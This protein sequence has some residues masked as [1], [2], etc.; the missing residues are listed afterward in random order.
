MLS[1]KNLKDVDSLK[2]LNLDIIMM[3][4]PPNNNWSFN[5]LFNLKNNFNSISAKIDNYS[6]TQKINAM[7]I[8]S[9]V[10][11]SDQLNLD[12]Y[13]YIITKNVLKD[14]VNLFSMRN[15]ILLINSLNVFHHLPMSLDGKREI[16][17]ICQSFYVPC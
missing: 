16:A 3:K 12:F 1:I 10:Q 11:R 15:L 4:T 6:C 17:L 2:I 14:S 7:F 9:F 5:M 8:S 13:S